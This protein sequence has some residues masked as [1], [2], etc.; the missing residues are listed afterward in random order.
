MQLT[1]HT[2]A[3]RARV[4]VLL[5]LAY[6]SGYIDRYALTILM[7]DVAR[8]F[9]VGDSVMGF[10]VGPA[11]ALFF[12][13]AGLPVARLADRYPR[14]RILAIGCVVWSAF[15]LLSGCARTVTEFALARLGVGLGEAACLAPSYS[16]IA[17][18]F[19]RGRR[20]LA[21]GF[22][23]QSV[24][25]GQIAGL[26]WG[27]ALAAVGGW[28]MTY[29]AIGVPGLIVAPLVWWLIREPQKRGQD[30]A[31]AFWPVAQ[32]IVRTR[33]F[34]ALVVGAAAATFAG[35]GFAYFM[36]TL[37]RRVHGMAQAEVG[38]R[39]GLL[40]GLSSMGGALLAGLLAQPGQRR[41]AVAPMRV[42]SV[43]VVLTMLGIF[44]V[45]AAPDAGS[46]LLWVVPTGL[47]NGAWLVPVQAALQDMVAET[48]RATAVA[49]FACLSLVVG[50]LGPWCVGALSDAFGWVA[51]GRGLA[52][53]MAMVA[54][55]SLVSAAGFHR[56]HRWLRTLSV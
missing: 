1:E 11:F 34:S 14:A 40:W 29:F 24:Y 9:S 46:A 49:V 42:S 17:D 3:Y 30:Q 55:A 43:S 47:A 28:R 56:A 13:L 27:G 23:N 2:K 36:P 15:T 44:A 5:M 54:L 48:E 53:A 51:G 37:L 26:W 22:F 6:T 19:P 41:G 20:S 18:T 32:R 4:V 25:L 31:D 21:V 33:G 50:F 52:L 10:L 38:Q 7:P 16:L 12:T 39:F 35:M 45:C 8:T